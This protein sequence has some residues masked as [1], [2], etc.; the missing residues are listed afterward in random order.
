MDL[1]KVLQGTNRDN[2][3]KPKPELVDDVALCLFVIGP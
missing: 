2:E 1:K 3:C